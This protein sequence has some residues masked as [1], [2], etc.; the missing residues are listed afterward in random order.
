MEKS[1][2]ITI[3]DVARKAG[4]SKGTV[5]RV[6]HNRGE[7]SEQ[8]AKRVRKAIAELNYKPN[9][10]A[11]LLATRRE[12]HVACLLPRSEE[13]EYWDMIYKGCLKGGEQAAALNVSVQVFLYDQYDVE[14]FR[15]ASEE[16]LAS[17]PIGVVMPPLFKSAT[18]EFSERLYQKHIPYV[19]IDS[20]VEDLHYLAYFGMPPYNSGV[21][22]ADLLTERCKPEEVNDIVLVRL[23]RDKSGLSDPTVD[24]RA[25]FVDYI[26][27]HFPD[28]RMHNVFIE[29]KDEEAIMS[30]LE[31]FHDEHPGLKLVTV[32]NSRVH[33]LTPFLKRHPDPD[34]RVI[35]Y[36]DLQKNLEALREHVVTILVGQN[37][38]DYAARSVTCI[39]D[40]CLKRQSPARR[41]NYVHMEILTAL[42]I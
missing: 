5:D 28:C 6:L 3:I 41:D 42:N 34:R 21:L 23:K 30:T 25:G 24:R 27:S 17:N 31:A 19:Y 16:V 26:E 32:F 22:V 12:M 18:L 8:S 7:V 37:T 38:K 39:V 13:G 11:S 9:L 35:G 10:Y 40:Y 36:D 20:K 14:S 4:V 33:L 29:P 15:S 1:A 2:K